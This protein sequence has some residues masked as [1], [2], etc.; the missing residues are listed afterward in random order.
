MSSIKE[1][2]ASIVTTS[3]PNHL[4]S[5]TC[6]ANSIK[7]CNEDS[8]S[9]ASN[10]NV[11]HTRS[12]FASPVTPKGPM[13]NS[14]KRR[15]GPNLARDTPG[16]SH[17]DSISAIF[18]D[19]GKA[20]HPLP[21]PRPLS[22]HLRKLHMPL[23]KPRNIWGKSAMD[24][25]EP[26]ATEPASSGL[27]TPIV[28]IKTKSGLTSGQ[29]SYP[30]LTRLSPPGIRT[31]H[32]VGAGTG[33]TADESYT[34]AFGVEDWLVDSENHPPQVIKDSDGI[35]TARLRNSVSP[36]RIPVASKRGLRDNSH[37]PD[38]QSSSFLSP[39]STTY[40]L[41]PRGHL[42]D[43]PKRK[44][45]RLSPSKTRSPARPKHNFV[46][47]DDGSSDRSADLSP[48]VEKYRKGNR[49]KRKRC[50]SYWDEDI[51]PELKNTSGEVLRDTGGRR[52]LTKAKVFMDGVENTYFDSEV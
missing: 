33:A 40:P 37:P 14:G 7:S 31:T 35:S 30:D 8:G 36:S 11:E 29:V 52:S 16:S 43:P 34:S 49:P 10:S 38:P 1:A 4:Q 3:T 25:I 47:Y 48:S 15:T 28:N 19:A 42:T 12:Q 45:P 24:N 23:S 32:K 22:A 9:P 20:L 46:F 17:Y 18:E 44:L 6:D 13:P 5:L 2:T 39:S 50:V 21:S 27:T 41:T 26:F 51:V